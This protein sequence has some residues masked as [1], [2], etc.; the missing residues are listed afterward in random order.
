MKRIVQALTV[1][2][3]LLALFGF[4]VAFFV[5]PDQSFSEQE[6]R[7]LRM[8]PKLTLDGLISGE[9]AEAVN[10]YFADQF[11]L[12]DALVGCKGVAEVLAGRGENNGILLGA[13]GQLARRLF[14][15]RCADGETVEDTDAFDVKHLKSS[16]EGL[17]RLSE[18]LDVPLTVMLTG[19]NIDVA[20]SAF[21]YPTNPSNA[22]LDTI[23]AEKR[24]QYEL[25]DTV[26]MYR[27]RFERGEYVY[28]KTDHHWTSLGAYLAYVEIMRSFGMENETKNEDFFAKT[29]V[30]E[31]FYGSLWSAGGM[32]FV[33]PD[34]V[35]IWYGADDGDYTVTADG[36]QLEGFYTLSHLEK[37]DQYSVFLDGTH[38]VVTVTKKSGEER[39]VLLIPKDSFANSLAP[40]LA[41]H[42]DLVLVNL[43]SKN[44]FTNVSDLA[45]SYGA[46]RVLIVYTIENVITADRL[47]RLK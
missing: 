42:F 7:S 27:E 22:L 45:K 11:P 43:S 28:Y 17:S 32:K 19:R 35:E 10:D 34:R 13:D 4:S 38:D 24:G 46:D 14:S 15:I 44:D 23:R 30:S 3:F 21:D 25:L 16:M 39:P 9:Y 1:G 12:R 8:S 5:L 31:D 29:V 26:P 18:H 47:C 40:F 33:P 2:M 36:K 6:N 37:K 41:R 20:A